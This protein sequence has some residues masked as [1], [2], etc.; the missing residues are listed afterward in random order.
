MVVF[1]PLLPLSGYAHVPPKPSD[2]TDSHKINNF[3]L[4]PQEVLEMKE[5][6]SQM[7]AG[8]EHLG[9]DDIQRMFILPGKESVSSESSESEG[10]IRVAFLDTAKKCFMY[11]NMTKEMILCDEEDT[12]LVRDSEEILASSLSSYAP[13]DSSFV[14][15]GYLQTAGLNLEGEGLGDFVCSNPHAVAIVAGGTGVAGALGAGVIG[16]GVVAGIAGGIVI[17]GIAK[18]MKFTQIDT[19]PLVVIGGVVTTLVVATTGLTIATGAGV[20]AGTAVA[21]LLGAGVVAIGLGEIHPQLC[22]ARG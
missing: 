14:P 18:K 10:M 6:A 4:G 22:P 11:D 8:L 21:M 13:V 16:V 15:R 2:H 1:V 12:V 3:S 20:I 7:K 17:G 19:I 5:Q 9:A